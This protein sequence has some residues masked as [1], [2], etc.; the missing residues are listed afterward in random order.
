M[1]F[2][3]TRRATLHL[4]P[5]SAWEGNAIEALLPHHEGRAF[6]AV[7]YEAEPRNEN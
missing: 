3:M 6:V 7:R 5:G 1:Q 2:P 4:F